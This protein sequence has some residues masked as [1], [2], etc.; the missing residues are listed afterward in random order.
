MKVRRGKDWKMGGRTR[1]VTVTQYILNMV[2]KG[3]GKH[4]SR[5]IILKMGFYKKLLV[6]FTAF[7]T[8]LNKLLLGLLILHRNVAE[9][10]QAEEGIRKFH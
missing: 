7:D 2:Y 5:R 9:N 4:I 1:I 3:F 8:L 6:I 10:G